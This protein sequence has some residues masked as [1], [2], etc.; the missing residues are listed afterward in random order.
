MFI[1]KSA[2]VLEGLQI[3]EGKSKRKESRDRKGYYDHLPGSSV[4]RGDVAVLRLPPPLLT[5]GSGRLP[6]RPL[7]LAT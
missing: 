6:R 2:V 1:L 5:T 4:G 7:V 3:H